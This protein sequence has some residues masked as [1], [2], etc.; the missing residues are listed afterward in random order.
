M[1]AKFESSKDYNLAKAELIDQVKIALEKCKFKIVSVDES[2][3]KIYA[4]SKINFW[5][6]SE[7]IDVKIEDNGSVTMRSECYLPTQI[8]DWGKNRENVEKFFK[9]LG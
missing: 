9:V 2:S 1:A 8:V 4:K 6:F 5:S 7:K 3:G